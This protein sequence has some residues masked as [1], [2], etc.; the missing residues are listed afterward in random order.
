MAEPRPKRLTKDYAQRLVHQW[1]V[2]SDD[3]EF[4]KRHCLKRMRQRNISPRQVLDCLRKGVITEGPYV[5]QKSGE[6]KV[7][8][9]RC[10][11]GEELTCSV[12]LLWEEKRLRVITVL[13]HKGRKAP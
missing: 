7:N 6:W 12:V 2:N 1:A 10:P 5:D 13:P 3:V 8:I 11:P 9:T 4:E